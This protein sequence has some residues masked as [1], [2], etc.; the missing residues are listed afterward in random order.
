[1]DKGGLLYTATGPLATQP[2]PCMLAHLQVGQ[3]GHAGSSPS[4]LSPGQPPPKMDGTQK[5]NAQLPAQLGGVRLR[6]VSD[7]A[8]GVPSSSGSSYPQ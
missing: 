3:A 2:F 7:A 5:I 4:L 8:A 1:M 6:Y